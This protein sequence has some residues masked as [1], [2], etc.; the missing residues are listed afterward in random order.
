MTRPANFFKQIPEQKRRGN[1]TADHAII[2]WPDRTRRF[3]KWTTAYRIE[4]DDQ[5]F[6]TGGGSVQ[7]QIEQKHTAGVLRQASGRE[8][9]TVFHLSIFSNAS[10]AAFKRVSRNSDGY[11]R[12]CRIPRNPGSHTDIETSIFL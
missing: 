4:D 10:Q 12:F 11:L 9:T 2:V 6:G 5:R 8:L 1:L 7:R 3:K